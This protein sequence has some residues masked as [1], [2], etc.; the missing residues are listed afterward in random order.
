M[1]CKK[2]VHI[3]F[4]TNQNPFITSP[5]TDLRPLLTPA[6]ARPR[7]TPRPQCLQASPQRGLRASASHPQQA[8]ALRVDLIDDGQKVVC[9][10]AVSPMNLVHPD[11]FDPAQFP[12]RQAPLH[13]PF[14]RPIHRFPTGLER[15][16]RFPP[17][18]PSR[19]ACQEPHHG[20]CHGTLAVAPRNVLDYHPVLSTLHPPWRVAKLGWDSPQG[21]K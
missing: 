21:H 4:H 18:H 3:S 6:P 11:G 10:Q 16:R 12:V 19:P 9:P 8:P 5:P 2:G 1:T 20:A 13:K 15:S 17:A 7:R 14:H